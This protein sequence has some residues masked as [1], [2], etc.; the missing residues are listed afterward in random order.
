MLWIVNTLAM[1]SYGGTPH[2]SVFKY[3]GMSPV[4][5]SWQCTN[6]VPNS[7]CWIA[8]SA[9]LAKNTNRSQLSL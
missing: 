8:S 5:Q 6:S 4:C 2:S 9:A 1:E 7:S 3:T